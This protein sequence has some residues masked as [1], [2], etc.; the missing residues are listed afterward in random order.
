MMDA[1]MDAIDY[2][3]ALHRIALFSFSLFDR[4]SPGLAPRRC[5]ASQHH[6]ACLSHAPLPTFSDHAS[7]SHGRDCIIII[8]ISI[9][10]A[11]REDAL[12]QDRASDEP[13]L[14]YCPGCLREKCSSAGL[15]AGHHHHHHHQLCSGERTRGEGRKEPS[16]RTRRRGSMASRADS[17]AGKVG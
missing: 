11:G 3:I 6:S 14:P 16:A 7:S 10:A 4:T 15:T 2:R 17:G 9:F 1:W 5:D 12:W 13:T 8:A